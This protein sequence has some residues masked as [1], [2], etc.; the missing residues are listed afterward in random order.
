MG[1]A[2]R[3]GHLKGD[4]MRVLDASEISTA[5]EGMCRE[6][7]TS[8]APGLEAA[9]AWAMAASP[10]GPS[11]EALA[12][13]LENVGIAAAC[14]LPLCQDTGVP[15]FLAEIGSGVRIEGGTLA[16]AVASGVSSSCRDGFLRPSMVSD[17]FGCRL[18]TGDSTPPVVHVEMVEGA[19]LRLGLVLRGAGTENASRVSM[20][21][22]LAGAD[23]IA[24]FVTEAVASNGAFACP[25]LVV[26]VGIGGNLETCAIL[27][28]K[29]LLRRFGEASRDTV[30]AALEKRLLGEVNALGIGPQGFGGPCTALSV[31]V[32]S[33][34]CH[35]ASLPA[36]VCMGCPAL[37]TA[38]A[39]L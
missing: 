19:S 16:S 2:G 5:V 17:P 35:M 9:L 14:G 39:V 8:P 21:P 22:P 37:R 11:R 1:G 25:P 18:N 6:A 36:C 23:G 3:G 29:G 10:P 7:S 26:S 24:G 33:A 27:A 34:P 15:V 20:L 30:C 4:G 31:R 12:I 13:C 28:K 32:T 38:E